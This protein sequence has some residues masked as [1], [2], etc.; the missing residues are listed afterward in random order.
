[1]EITELNRIKSTASFKRHPWELA[2]RKI[3]YSF[4]IKTKAPY[5]TIIDFGSGDTFLLHYLEQQNIAK[6]YFAVDN[7]YSPE[8]VGAVKSLYEPSAVRYLQDLVDIDQNAP[9]AD[10]LLL[11][12]VIEHCENDLEILQNATAENVIA[13]NATILI[14]VPACPFVF[15]AHD[16]LLN[17]YRRYSLN[18]LVKLCEQAGLRISSKGYFF[19]TLLVARL[20]QVG[21][22]KVKLRTPSK[23]LDNWHGSKSLTIA[24][25][26]LLWIDFKIGYLVNKAGI[27]LPG[28][29]AYC[30]CSKR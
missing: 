1:M 18:Q 2:R 26:L 29:S 15:S 21:L 14:T 19:F 20:F 13:E 6:K 28:L 10:C 5:E 27:R 9:L 12:D 22:E 7:A 3:I 25:T 4:L 8:I 17:H 30:I 11:L 24:L 23:S 16:H